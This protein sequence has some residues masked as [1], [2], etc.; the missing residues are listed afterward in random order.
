MCSQEKKQ[1]LG[2]TLTYLHQGI[3][4]LFCED[5]SGGSVAGKDAGEYVGKGVTGV[6][7]QGLGKGITGA[8]ELGKGVTGEAVVGDVVR[9]S[10]HVP[11]SISQRHGCLMHCFIDAALSQTNCVGWKDG[12]WL[13][14]VVSVGI[15]DDVGC[16]DGLTRKGIANTVVSFH[17]NPPSPPP[18][19]TMT[20][21]PDVKL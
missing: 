4:S 14:I 5:C 10:T 2:Q 20:S 9:A 18:P 8:Q 21:P 17:T 1:S 3:R 19:I 16:V 6:G 7:A 13:G 11:F 12:N 15:V